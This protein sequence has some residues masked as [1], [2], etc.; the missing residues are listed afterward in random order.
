M[1][2]CRL[3]A[4]WMTTV[5]GGE[6]LADAR[7]GKNG[8]HA[9]AGLLRQSLF[10]RLAGYEGVND[11]ERLRRDP[12]MRWLVGGPAPM[13]QPALARQMGTTGQA[14]GGLLQPA[15]HCRSVDKR[16]RLRS[17]GRMPYFSLPNAVRLSFMRWPTI[18]AISCGRWRCPRRRSHGR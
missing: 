14:R 15:R 11:A 18:S 10:G 17:G 8:R 5:A 12:A 1:A 9:L 13:D 4:S 16:R 3:I 6:I 2:D 7:A